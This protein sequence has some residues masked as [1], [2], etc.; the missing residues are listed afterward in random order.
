MI[1]MPYEE[2]AGEVETQ[3]PDKVLVCLR[4]HFV[5]PD[6]DNQQRPFLVLKDLLK[7]LS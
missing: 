4:Y 1:Q 7:S 5:G 2:R 6:R 3:F